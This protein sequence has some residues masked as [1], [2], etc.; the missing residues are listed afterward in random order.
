MDNIK[1][2]EAQDQKHDELAESLNDLF[3]S[4]TTMI[5]SELQVKPL[6]L[7]ANALR[8]EIAPLFRKS[9]VIFIDLFCHNL[10]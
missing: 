9:T 5:K 2:D 3:S 8:Y 7:Y 1:K 4:V 10:R 6:T